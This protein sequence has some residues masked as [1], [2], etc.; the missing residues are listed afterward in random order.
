MENPT[1]GGNPTILYKCKHP[2]VTS[3]EYGKPTAYILSACQ[4]SITF[5]T[6]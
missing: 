3:M 6:V 2:S 4:F 1:R 5:Q